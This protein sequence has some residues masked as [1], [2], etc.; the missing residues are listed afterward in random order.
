MKV[1]REGV[2]LSV[3]TRG[4]SMPTKIPAVGR[5]LMSAEWDT[6]SFVEDKNATVIYGDPKAKPLMRGRMCS[7]WWHPEKKEYKISLR[8]NPKESPSLAEWAFEDCMNYI[9]R[10]IADGKDN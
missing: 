7:V 4:N 1:Y 5:F 10:R 8:V 2:N 3:T 6:A 9:K